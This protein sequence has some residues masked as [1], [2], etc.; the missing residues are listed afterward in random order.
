M[1]RKSIFYI[2]FCIVICSYGVRAEE[3]GGFFVEIEPGQSNDYPQHWEEQPQTC[4]E[5]ILEESGYSLP[6]EQSFEQNIE[7]LPPASYIHFPIEDPPVY[8]QPSVSVYQ[9]TIL[10]TVMPV[11]TLMTT[12]VLF[13]HSRPFPQ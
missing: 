3:M 7:P 9:E 1:N 6:E 10:P 8:T 2:S 11:P 5:I 4:Q 12:E 13:P